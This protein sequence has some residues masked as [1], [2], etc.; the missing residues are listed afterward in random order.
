MVFADD[1]LDETEEDR[2]NDSCLQGLSKDDEE[3]WNGEHVRHLGEMGRLEERAN[4]KVGKDM[5]A[6]MTLG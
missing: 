1:L 6:Q 3:D 2:Y 4:T 5:A